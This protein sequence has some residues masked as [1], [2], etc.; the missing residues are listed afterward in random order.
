ML[1]SYRLGTRFIECLYSYD[2]IYLFYRV[3]TCWNLSLL[4]VLPE[5]GGQGIGQCITEYSLK[6]AKEMGAEIVWA[7]FGSNFSQKIGLKC[8][9]E[10]V[11]TSRYEQ[12]YRNYRNM[13]EVNRNTHK[14]CVSM[15][16][17]L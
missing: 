17:R 13:S 11:V 8:G 4:S 7:Y 5:Y 6:I 15:V 9:F 12:D 10:P 1:L 16:K 3:D 14:T 2:S